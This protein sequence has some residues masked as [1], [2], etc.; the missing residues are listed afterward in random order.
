M[1]PRRFAA[2][3]AGLAFVAGV[4][5]LAALAVVLPLVVGW[6]SVVV[7]SGS[8]SPAIHRGD[9]VLGQKYDGRVLGPGT[10]VVFRDGDR[11][12]LS[13]RIVA[14]NDDGTY[15]TRGDANPGPDSTPLRPDQ[16][17]ATGR[18]LVPRIGI[19]P[20]L[21]RQGRW[22][23][24][25]VLMAL[26]GGASVLARW[27]LRGNPRPLLPPVTGTGLARRRATL[28][29]GLVAAEL[30]MALVALP[31]ARAAWMAPTSNGASSLAAAPT[32]QQWYLNT[33]VEG[34]NAVSAPW[35]TMT[36]TA[37]VYNGAL[38]NYDTNRNTDVGL[39]VAPTTL[40]LAESDPSKYQQWYVP[41]TPGA[42]QHTGNY[43]LR[44]PTAV[45]NF[46]PTAKGKMIAG[47]YT[48]ASGPSSCSLEATATVDRPSGWSNSLTT[49]VETIF[50]FGALDFSTPG[51]QD[52]AVKVV[53]DSAGS[54]DSMWLAY[55][56]RIYAAALQRT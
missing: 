44:L 54:D 35:L 10:V 47:L 5:W 2:G 27:G 46:N 7:T 29:G 51:N 36:T 55:D 45:R 52:I 39:T 3:L 17:E 37:P 22:G 26:L 34:A 19:I 12:L 49:F 6:K 28:V 43:R 15:T 1:S 23:D 33:P 20:V 14:R 9:V 41:P 21:A 18:A 8:M 16:I 32:W 25:A 56:T 31:G 50:D 24:L 53:V 4:V 30:A 38:P 11:G 42:K 13:H 48:C 40:G